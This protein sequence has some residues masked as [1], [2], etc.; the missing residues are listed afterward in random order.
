MV[1][2]ADPLRYLRLFAHFI[3]LRYDFWRKRLRSATRT[4]RE[5]KMP[6]DFVPAACTDSADR[7]I[8]TRRCIA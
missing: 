2:E 5:A 3:S 6:F 1:Y 4:V 8:L 7:S